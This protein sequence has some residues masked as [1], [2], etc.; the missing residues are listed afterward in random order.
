MKIVFPNPH[1][2][3]PTSTEETNFKVDQVRTSNVA[4]WN[5][6]CPSCRHNFREHGRDGCLLCPCSIQVKETP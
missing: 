5:D 6:K 3:E 2:I 1:M 4:F